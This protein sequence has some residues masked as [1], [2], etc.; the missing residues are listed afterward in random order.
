MFDHVR[1][2]FDAI[3]YANGRFREMAHQVGITVRPLPVGTLAEI[4]AALK[5]AQ[6]EQ[7]Q[8]LM[9][10]PSP[11][12]VQ[13]HHMIIKSLAHRV[14]VLGVQRIWAKAGAVESFGPDPF[15]IFRRSAG[16]VDKILKGAKPGDLP[17]EQP[18]KF[19]LVVNLRAA[20]LVGIKIPQSVVDRADEV[21][22]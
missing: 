19:S 16:Y 3:A 9:I 1:S 10:W 4:K 5:T 11:L 6:K 12:I 15:D 18:Q 8:A 14:P 13:H 22:R 7:A 17:I 2:D 21:I 20:K